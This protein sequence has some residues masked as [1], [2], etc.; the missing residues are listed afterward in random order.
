[1][2]DNFPQPDLS[3][4]ELQCSMHD[5]VERVLMPPPA[6]S[7]GGAGT[8]ALIAS[9]GALMFGLGASIALFQHGE[10]LP[11]FARQAPENFDRTSINPRR[12]QRQAEEREAQAPH[13][14]PAEVPPVVIPPPADPNQE[15]PAP[16][17]ESGA[18]AVPPGEPAIIIPEP[19]PENEPAAVTGSE[20]PLA[21]VDEPLEP[22]PIVPEEPPS[23]S[24]GTV[25]PVLPAVPL[26]SSVPL[27]PQEIGVF[28]TQTSVKNDKY[29]LA[30]LDQLKALGNG[31]LIFNVKGGYVHFAASAPMANELDLVHPSYDL[32][33]VIRQAR[34]RGV[35]TIGR[36][37]ALKDPNLAQALPE[38]QIK[39]PKT[40]R[41]VGNVWVDPGN[42]EVIVYNEQIFRDL[43]AAGIDEINLDYI[44]YPTEYA[45]TSIGLKGS[46][47]ADRIEA[48]LQMARRVIDE[49]GRKTKLG[50]STYAILGWNFPVNFEPL[51]QDIARFAPLVDVISPMA[52]PAT[53]AQGSY[54]NPARHPRSR[55]YYLVYRTLTG[56]REL[57]GDQAYKL[58]PWIQG[59]G[60]TQ[61][62]L[63]D[64]ID[65]VFDAGSCGFTIWNAS[66]EYGIFMRMLPEVKRPEHCT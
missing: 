54:Y 10:H 37:V 66:N 22:A 47:K 51:G 5:A 60:I 46:E 9:T 16:L 31:A 50:I 28:F 20:V 36:F 55:M 3:L 21:P 59:Y 39:H 61:K 19:V 62:N 42:E 1:M 49:N 15:A 17:H 45:Q 23:E 6:R 30:T 56:Y 48:F 63:K 14:A 27:P 7:L 12:V 18:A 13:A 35:T 25:D 65:A 58:R 24:G 32:P 41:S 34:E 29:F 43:V 53:F 44:R 40:D 2:P 38:T 52:Y 4:T 11:V 64:E 8:L 57:L 33:E 26:P